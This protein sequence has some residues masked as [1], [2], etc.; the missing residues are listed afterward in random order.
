MSKSRITREGPNGRPITLRAFG[1]SNQ[2]AIQ[3]GGR[4]DGKYVGT[5]FE[6]LDRRRFLELYTRFFGQRAKEAEA[7]G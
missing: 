4:I 7:N 6:A 2:R 1:Q 5:I 3:Y